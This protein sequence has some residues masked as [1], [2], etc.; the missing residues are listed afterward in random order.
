MVTLLF[1]QDTS[2]AHTLAGICNSILL[3]N[4]I[5][6]QAFTWDAAQGLAFFKGQL[7]NSPISPSHFCNSPNVTTWVLSAGALPDS[8][9]IV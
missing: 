1:L 7:V 3:N 2:L 9:K 6:C 5:V 4:T 8:T